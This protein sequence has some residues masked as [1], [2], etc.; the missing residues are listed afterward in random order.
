MDI[1]L[2]ISGGILIGCIIALSWFAGS[3]A[4]YVPTKMDKI[5][6]IL[7]LAG[8]KK[9]P[10]F[11]LI[12]K[13]FYELGSGDGRVVR[14]AARLGAKAFGIEQSW[15]RVLYSR[16]KSHNLKLNN[17]KFM[18]GNI[19]K[20][21]YKDADIVYIYLLSKAVKRLEK[22]LSNELKKESVMI[23]Q[24]YHFPT[25]KPFKKTDDFWFYKT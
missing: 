24:T 16:W 9:T 3:D 6:E 22:K 2:I 19:F 18:H 12:G 15:I 5:K 7:K 14:E 4:P 10:V 11:P 17:A 1:T 21:N 25:L 8:D 20:K 23:T 13:K